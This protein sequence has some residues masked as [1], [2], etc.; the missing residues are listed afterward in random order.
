MGISLNAD[1]LKRYKDIAWLLVKYG[2]SDLVTQIG[3][4]AGTPPTGKRAPESHGPHD[5]LADELADD[6]E[7]LGP[8]F[9]KLGQL[10]STRPDLLPPD[11]TKSLSRLQDNVGP[12]PFAEVEQIV[13][14]ELGLKLSKGFSEF[15]EKPLAAASLGQVHFARLRDGRPVAVKVQRPGIGERVA[16][17]L[18]ALDEESRAFWMRTPRPDATI[19]SGA[20]YR[21]FGAR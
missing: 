4:E 3:L 16:S 21:N 17:D 1:H 20:Y 10:L 18:D 19:N 15:Q 5:P 7:Q 2:R 14:S 8:T 6:L 12:F 13:T 9:I 11:F